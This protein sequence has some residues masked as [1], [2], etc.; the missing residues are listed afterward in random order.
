[1]LALRKRWT[2]LADGK[3]EFLQPA[4]RKVLAYLLKGEAETVLVVANLSRH[5][6]AVPLDLAAYKDF[7][8]I[9]LFGHATFPIISEQPY[10][11]T[12]SPYAA[13]WFL[14]EPKSTTSARNLSELQPLRVER[15]WK[16]LLDPFR[17][18]QLEAR[19]PRF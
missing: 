13:F 9:E 8:P 4:N 12:L 5:A 17:A 15:A 2:A 18:A 14:L 16:E 7:V 6:Q 10:L 11:I 1:M 3:I 19:L